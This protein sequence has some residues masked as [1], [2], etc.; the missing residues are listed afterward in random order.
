MRVDVRDGRLEEVAAA[1][2]GDEQQG[3]GRAA[4]HWA[5]EVVEEAVLSEVLGSEVELSESFS[6]LESVPSEEVDLFTA[7]KAGNS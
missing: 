2:Q 7:W 1:K 5:S 3:L 4:H 6:E